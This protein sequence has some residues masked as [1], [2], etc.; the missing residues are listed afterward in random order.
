MKRA[1][2][3]LI[4]LA[5][6]LVAAATQAADVNVIFYSQQAD[7]PVAVAE[8][9]HY[10]L[11]S[12]DG[13]EAKVA[14]ETGAETVVSVEP[15]TYS[16][17]AEQPSTHLFGSVQVEI[18]ADQAEPMLFL[19]NTEGLTYL[20]GVHPCGCNHEGYECDGNCVCAIFNGNVTTGVCSCPDSCGC[21]KKPAYANGE[22]VQTSTPIDQ[23]CDVCGLPPQSPCCNQCGNACCGNGCWWSTLGMLG[24]IGALIAVA[25]E[26]DPGDTPP[27]V[28]PTKIDITKWGTK[29]TT[30]NGKKTTIYGPYY[31]TYPVTPYRVK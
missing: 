18:P 6:M 27:P 16:V 11:V 31:Y 22:V 23:A 10:S 5:G 4:A 7:G 28:S 15:G 8:D 1:T 30:I 17:V 3:L 26:D 29:T 25:V 14:D 24:A 12:T 21:H 13:Q 2:M 9:V 19:L 20:E